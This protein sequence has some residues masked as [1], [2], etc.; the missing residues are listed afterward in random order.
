LALKESSRSEPDCWIQIDQK[1]LRTGYR[2]AT[3]TAR[4]SN[5]LHQVAQQSSEK[6]AVMPLKQDLLQQVA[7]GCGVLVI[8][9]MVVFAAIDGHDAPE[10]AQSEGTTTPAV[11]VTPVEKGVIGG[12]D[13]GRG[14]GGGHSGG[15]GGHSGGGGNGGRGGPGA[16]GGPGPHLG[17]AGP[18]G[19]N[20]AN[21]PGPHGGKGTLNDSGVILIPQP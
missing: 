20:R 14:H 17:P 10:P 4:F 16:G 9:A 6:D 2:W 3:V 11:R 19:A 15:G 7:A 12:L 13:Q 18:A 8:G 5:D 1:Q 21:Q